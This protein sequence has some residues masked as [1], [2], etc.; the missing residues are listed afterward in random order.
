MVFLMS[1]LS[2]PGLSVPVSKEHLTVGGAMVSAVH[3]SGKLGKGLQ[4]EMENPTK[5]PKSSPSFKPLAFLLL[6]PAVRKCWA[7]GFKQAS[8][9]QP[10]F[11]HGLHKLVVVVWKIEADVGGGGG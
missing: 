1:R 5:P 3:D 11:G 6:L 8:Q 9:N 4:G 7:P 10:G 2:T